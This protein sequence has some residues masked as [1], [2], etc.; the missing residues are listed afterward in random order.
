MTGGAHTG[1]RQLS[2]VQLLRFLSI[3]QSKL[4]V[5]PPTPKSGKKGEKSKVIRCFSQPFNCETQP[6]HDTFCPGAARVA[7]HPQARVAAH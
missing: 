1:V 5:Y 4:S 6:S 2:F 7:A 3:T